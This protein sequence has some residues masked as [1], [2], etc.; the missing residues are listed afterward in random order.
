MRRRKGRFRKGLF[1]YKLDILLKW[2]C[3]RAY[4]EEEKRQIQEGALLV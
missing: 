3:Q 1:L 2:V 4:N